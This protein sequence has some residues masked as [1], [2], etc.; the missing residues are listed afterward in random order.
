MAVYHPI[1]GGLFRYLCDNEPLNIRR[2]ADN[3]CWQ[4]LLKAIDTHACCPSDKLLWHSV[5]GRFRLSAE[6]LLVD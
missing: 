4:K 3:K 2:V 6:L 5:E 1:N